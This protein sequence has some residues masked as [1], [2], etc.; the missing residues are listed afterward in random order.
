MERSGLVV[1]KQF[2]NRIIR[3]G[4]M[5]GAIIAWINFSLFSLY[6]LCALIHSLKDKWVWHSS[7]RLI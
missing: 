4:D 2:L 6:E 7:S 3:G 1:V 5:G